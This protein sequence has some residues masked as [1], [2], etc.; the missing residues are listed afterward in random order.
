MSWAMMEGNPVE[1][2]GFWA[3]GK[4]IPVC[5]KPIWECNYDVD[6]NG[7]FTKLTIYKNNQPYWIYHGS[8]NNVRKVLKPLFDLAANILEELSIEETKDFLT[9]LHLLLH[10]LKSLPLY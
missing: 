3:A 4:P 10:N 6:A 8:S 9:M 7:T 2:T 1:P 5:K